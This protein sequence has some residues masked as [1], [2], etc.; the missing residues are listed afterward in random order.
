MFCRAQGEKIVSP[1]NH[2]LKE[3]GMKEETSIGCT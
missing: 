3:I 1:A 2:N